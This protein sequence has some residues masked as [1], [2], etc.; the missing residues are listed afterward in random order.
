MDNFPRIKELSRQVA[1][2]LKDPEL[3]GDCI[4]IIA[5]Q[6]LANPNFKLEEWP[7]RSLVRL[8]ARKMSLGTRFSEVKESSLPS[9]IDVSPIDLAPDMRT[10]EA[11]LLEAQ[12]E[13]PEQTYPAEAYS[14]MSID[15]ELLLDDVADGLGYREFRLLTGLATFTYYSRIHRARSKVFVKPPNEPMVVELESVVL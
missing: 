15:Q 11:L 8:V 9:D 12:E 13:E 1:L 10:P 7:V 6:I 14:I 5:E 4:G 3:E 2:A